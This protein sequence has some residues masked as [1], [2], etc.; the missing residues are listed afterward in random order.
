MSDY[1]Q[2]DWN[3]IALKRARRI[4]MCGV[5][6]PHGVLFRGNKERDIR[7]GIIDRDW[8]EAVI[9]LPPNLFYG[10][11]ILAVVLIFNKGKAAKCP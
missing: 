6:M 4:G 5:V 9:G 2:L 7:Q 10:T 8:L 1:R 3:Q 11:G